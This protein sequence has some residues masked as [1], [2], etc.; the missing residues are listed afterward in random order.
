MLLSTVNVFES[1]V[2]RRRLHSQLQER[3]SVAFLMVY[4]VTQTH[5]KSVD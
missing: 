2:S 5:T 4:Q 1:R 3:L